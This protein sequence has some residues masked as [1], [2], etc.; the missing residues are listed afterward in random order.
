MMANIGLQDHECDAMGGTA[1]PSQ[2]PKQPRRRVPRIAIARIMNPSAERRQI[3]D[4][5]ARSDGAAPIVDVTYWPFW[6]KLQIG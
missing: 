1:I 6:K 2:R 3:C 5:H 4:H